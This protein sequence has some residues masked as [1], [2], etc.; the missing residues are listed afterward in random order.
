MRGAL[1]D[2]LAAAWMRVSTLAAVVA[3][4]FATIVA[5]HPAGSAEAGRPLDKAPDGR[6][7][8][9]TF[10]EDFDRFRPYDEQT[11]MGVWRTTFGAA[12]GDEI[13]QRTLKSNG[14]LQYYVDPGMP[15]AD[16]PFPIDPFRTHDGVLEI[17][18]NRTPPE[19]RGRL[20]GYRYTSGLITTQPSFQQQYGYFEMRALL[21]K[22]KGLWPAFWMLPSDLSWPPEIDILESLGDPTRVFLTLHSTV[23]SPPS[24]EARTPTPGFHVFAASWDAENVIWYIDGHEVARQPTPKDMHRPMYLL[25]NLAVG[26]HWAGAPDSTTRLPATLTIDYIRAYRFGS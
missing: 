15:H 4:V 13:D 1:I 6:R 9:L 23:A 5:A 20:G 11:H 25:A 2:S 24:V 8:V 17:S 14:E 22:G 26:G 16:G 19:L 7:L 18:A 21:P 12:R 10:F 3:I